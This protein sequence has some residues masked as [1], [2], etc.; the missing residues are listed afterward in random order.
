MAHMPTTPGGPDTV[1]TLVHYDGRRCIE[2]RTADG[3]IEGYYEA[4]FTPTLD[5]GRIDD[6][7]QYT[8]GRRI[9]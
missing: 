8:K 9:D 2:H 5:N 3:L 1:D 6:I 4:V 7:T